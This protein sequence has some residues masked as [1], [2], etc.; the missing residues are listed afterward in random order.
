L[1]AIFTEWSPDF[2]L[3]ARN[4]GSMSFT[5]L[6][7]HILPGIDDGPGTMEESVALACAAAAEGTRVIVATPHVHEHFVTD[8]SVLQNRVRKVNDALGR[9]RVPIRVL[10]GGE[11]A[12]GMVARLGPADLDVIAHGPKGRR[13]LLLEAPLERIEDGFAPAAAELRERGFG[14]VIAHPERALSGSHRSW[15]AIEHELA[16][17]SALQINAWSVAGL[18][19]DQVQRL[20]LSA[21]RT[22]QLVALASDAHGPER[23]PSL[24]LGLEALAAF[25]IPRPERYAD[26]IPRALLERGLPARAAPVAA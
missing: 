14:I 9:A 7:F 3:I 10:C 15:G 8:V 1:C 17:G 22:T 16:A 25:G 6:H 4:I 19:G 24:R 18:Y 23:M 20:A 2:A 26:E 21:I 5:E 11:L 13:W 12:H